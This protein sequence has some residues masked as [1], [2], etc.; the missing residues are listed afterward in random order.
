MI[1]PCSSTNG[2]N[3]HDSIIDVLPLNLLFFVENRTS[4]QKLAPQSP[5]DLFSSNNLVNPC[6]V[7]KT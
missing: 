5:F 1:T 7:P 2:V 6:D 4:F 3:L